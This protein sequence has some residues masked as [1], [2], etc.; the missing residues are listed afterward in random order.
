MEAVAVKIGHLPATQEQGGGQ[1]RDENRLHEIDHEKG[2]ELH[3]AVFYEVTYDLG[4]ALRHIKG[5]ALVFAEPGCQ[6]QQET[7]GLQH[8]SPAW[9]PSPKNLSLLAADLIEIQGTEY[10]KQPDEG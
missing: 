5:N 3:A 2:A 1:R 10:H 8:Y 7:K 9:Q 4:F 6:E